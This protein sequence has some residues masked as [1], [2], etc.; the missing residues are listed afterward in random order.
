MG[1]RT[2]NSLPTTQDLANSLA[3]TNGKT[4]QE[5]LNI[6]QTMSALSPVVQTESPTA[7]STINVDQGTDILLIA[8]GSL[9][10]TLTINLPDAPT[11]RS[12]RVRI[13]SGRAITVVSVTTTANGLLGG[14]STMIINGFA[15]Y[16]FVNGSWYRSG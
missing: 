8:P 12:Q 11:T 4:T 3:R 16:L 15:E 6:A 2:E 10:L 14:I 1:G 9:L 13:L 7:G 5:A